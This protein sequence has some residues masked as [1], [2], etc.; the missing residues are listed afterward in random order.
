MKDLVICGE[1]L[2]GML[3]LH[4][5]VW[6]GQAAVI[7]KAPANIPSPNQANKAY[8]VAALLDRT[9]HRLFML[10]VKYDRGAVPNWSTHG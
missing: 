8:Y 10:C 9:L 7:K 3:S 5:C 6:P 2:S 4:L 1:V